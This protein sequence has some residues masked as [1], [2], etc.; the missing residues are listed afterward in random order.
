MDCQGSTEKPV[1]EDNKE[2]EE[3]EEEEVSLKDSSSLDIITHTYFSI[4]EEEP[5]GSL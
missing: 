4:L 1:S 2:E 3:E 5:L